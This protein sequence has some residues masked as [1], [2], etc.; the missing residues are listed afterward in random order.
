MGSD[1]VIDRARMVATECGLT[2]GLRTAEVPGIAMLYVSLAGT[3][4]GFVHRYPD[5][6]MTVHLRLDA[7]RTAGEALREIA[8]AWWADDTQ[9]AAARGEDGEGR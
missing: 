7:P 2:Y 4:H 1:V 3:E 9:R 5:G 6:C 8:R